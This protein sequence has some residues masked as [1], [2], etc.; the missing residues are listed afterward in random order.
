MKRVL[1]PLALGLVVGAAMGIA[2]VIG[3]SNESV[4]A[5]GAMGCGGQPENAF[6]VRFE[7]VDVYVDSGKVP[8]AA[9]EIEFKASVNN[10]DGEQGGVGAKVELV[11]VEGGEPGA[12]AK[13][14]FYDATV[15]AQKGNRIIVAAMSVGSDLP[16][17]N[18]R[19]ARLHVA[20][21]A[22]STPDYACS[23]VVAGDMGAK[24]IKATASTRIAEPIPTTAAAPA[25]TDA[26]KAPPAA[27]AAP[28][29][30]PA[31][32]R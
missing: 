28:P 6:A 30:T 21:P 16:M 12:F 4:G 23:I 15:L 3:E 29:P 19:V 14:P 9:Y 27:P 8:M 22:K 18:T 32:P 2:P 24:E 31:S 13:P 25:K 7:A 17:G 20:V 10:G 11:G 5:M 1:A 26:P